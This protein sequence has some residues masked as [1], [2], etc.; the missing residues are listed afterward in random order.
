M[1]DDRR[2]R[3]HWDEMA[4][5]RAELADAVEAAARVE[6]TLRAQIEQLERDKAEL[7]AAL[8]LWQQRASLD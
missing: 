6:A 3:W 5:M 7:L 8:R 2:P 1:G 4:A